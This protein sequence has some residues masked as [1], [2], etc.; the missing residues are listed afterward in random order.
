M[1]RI[2]SRDIV[3]EIKVVTIVGD[4]DSLWSSMPARTQMVLLRRTGYILCG[5]LLVSEFWR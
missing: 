5:R 2:E 3:T 1:K 4:R